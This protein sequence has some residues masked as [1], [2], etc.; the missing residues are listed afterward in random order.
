MLFFRYRTWNDHT[1]E[2]L[3]T[4]SVFASPAD[5]FE[6]LL[7]CQPAFEANHNLTNAEEKIFQWGKTN[8]FPDTYARQ[9][10]PIMAPFLI[11]LFESNPDSITSVAKHFQSSMGVTCFSRSPMIN[12]MW[13]KYA[14]NHAGICL[15]FTFN[16]DETDFYLP[17]GSTCLSPIRLHPVFYSDELPQPELFPT[18]GDY[19]ALYECVTTKEK[20]GNLN[21]NGA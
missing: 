6:D 14:D 2:S 1:K 4:N 11:D 5:K 15:C 19:R 21:E 7:D 18:P 3:R 8:N 12:E 17:E 16:D 10:A 20:N 9:I 13:I